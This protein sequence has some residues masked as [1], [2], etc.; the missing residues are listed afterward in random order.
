MID[1]TPTIKKREFLAECINRHLECQIQT[2]KK[3]TRQMENRLADYDEA[4][5]R[6]GRL[7][8]CRWRVNKRLDARM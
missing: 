6:H 2:S 5:R 1:I 3:L 8:G 4:I 7:E